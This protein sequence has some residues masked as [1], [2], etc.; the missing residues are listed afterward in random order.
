MKRFENTKAVVTGGASGIG[1]ALVGILLEEGARVVVIDKSPA[2]S[3][4]EYGEDFPME[5]VLSLQTDITREDE[6]RAAAEKVETFFGSPSML[7]NN[8]GIEHIGTMVETSADDWDRVMG[9]N[10]KGMF[11]I[12]KAILPLMIAGG[13]GAVVNVSSI[14]GI[15]G[16]PAS[17][18]YCTSKG[19]VIL[20]TKQMAVDFGKHNVR[21]N[22]VAP[23]TTKTPMIDRLLAD[24]K[25]LVSVTEMIKNRHPLK[26]FAEPREIAEAMLFLASE[27]ASFITGAVLP[28]D[29][30]YTSK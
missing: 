1:K 25:D 10:V 4:G 14:S 7:F 30:G 23:G 20:L 17:A 27:E 6:V 11:L 28:V 24:E 5:R 29:G 19:A 15:L 12:C 2:D 3:P 22:A 26:R 16:W 18:A 9:V 21:V 13:G 8:A